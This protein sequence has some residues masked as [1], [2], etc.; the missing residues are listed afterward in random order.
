MEYTFYELGWLFLIYSL[1]GWCLS[2]A[3][4]AVRRRTF[5]NTGVL[6]L[7]VSPVYGFS[8]AAISV[9]LTE[10]KSEFVFLF[11]GG[12]LLS[13]FVAFI[14]GIVLE[15]I[16][17]RKWTDDRKR[18]FSAG[19]LVSVLVLLTGG[20]G[21]I[22]VLWLG[23]PLI[24]RVMDWIPDTLGHILLIILLIVLALDLSGTL[25]TVWKWKR[26][27]ERVSALTDN[28]QTI[29]T[30]FGNA[31]TRAICHRLE[32]SYP[33]I[34]TKKLLADRSA[35]KKKT[36]TKFAEGCCFYK[37]ALIFILASLIG[38]LAEMVFCRF[39][40]GYW[41]SRSSLVYGPFS[42]IWGMA[43]VMLTAFLYAH[44]D[45]S[46]RYIFV[47]GTVAGGTYEYVCSVLAELVFGASFWN[48]SHIPFNL[49]GHI[50]LLFCFF[51]GCTAVIWLKMIYPRLSDLIEKIPIRTGKIITWILVVLMVID[52]AIS[53]MALIRYS[54][55]QNGIEASTQI[56][57]I[58]DEHF[59]DER[60][61][62]I[63]PKAKIVKK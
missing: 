7:P 53:A 1:V 36:A 12:M 5:V 11:I 20:G 60:M 34:E 28:M 24:L 33:N 10:L 52:M 43:C 26:H 31:I 38:D 42:V 27:I 8:A 47:Y 51:W 54:A 15:H 6:N 46:D 55:R 14:A 61:E 9:F 35:R 41:M 22:F 23:N 44:R 63:Y 17:H 45:K 18:R 56:E 2:V 62:R 4:E 49:G 48:Y 29:S 19:S 57:Q 40:L 21:A 50:N 32:R 16:F 59:T 39:S 3:L 58:L 30:S 13:A 37:L 25:A